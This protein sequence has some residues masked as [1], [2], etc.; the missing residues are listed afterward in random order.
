V[1]QLAAPSLLALLLTFGCARKEAPPAQAAAVT[2]T[3]VTVIPGF[4]T[5]ESV[6]WSA[7]EDVW[8][9]SNV[10]GAPTARDGNGFISRLSRDG[11]IDSLQFIAGG[12]D[13]VTLNGPKGMALVGDTLWVADI[14]AVRA[15]NARTGKPV[16]SVELGKQATFL[17]DVAVGPDGTIYITDSGIGFDDKGQVTHP[18]PDRIFALQGRTATIAAEGDWMERPNGITWDGANGR[19]IL[20][21][22]GGPHLLGWKPGVAKVDTIG[23]GPGG[24]DGVE[25]VDGE[26]LVTSWADSSVFSVSSAGNTK[27]VTG[28]NSP[29][30]IGVDQLRGLVSIPLFTENRVEVWRVK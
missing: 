1:K 9:V 19:F 20:V 6:I 29:A 14:D 30:D 15:F 4:S 3:R 21:P 28:V 5:P 23:T 22:F 12:R 13:S 10:N 11:V 2:P 8:F 26:L 18:G 17:N 24:Q 7:K 27:V 25:F 16:A